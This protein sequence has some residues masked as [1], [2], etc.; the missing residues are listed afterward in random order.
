MLVWPA[1]SRVECPPRVMKQAIMGESYKRPRLG[2]SEIEHR[3]DAQ[4]TVGKKRHPWLEDASTKS[5]SA[6][7]LGLPRTLT[8]IRE[9]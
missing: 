6:K 8:P 9:S 4:A 2:K 7:T 1:K 3:E 5:C